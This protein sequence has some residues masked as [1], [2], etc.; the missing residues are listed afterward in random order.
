M[1]EHFTGYK[2]DHRSKKAMMSFIEHHR[3]HSDRIYDPVTIANCVKLSHLPIPHDLGDSAYAFLESGLFDFNLHMDVTDFEIENP[4][5]TVY[6]AGRTGGWLELHKKGYRSI[7]SVY[8]PMIDD[9]APIEDIRDLCDVIEAFD[10]WCDYVAA[11]FLQEVYDFKAEKEAEQI[12]VERESLALV[13]LP[14]PAMGV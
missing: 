2:I 10:R 14:F 7:F 5:Y 13:E 3:V 9:E 11:D 6:Q 1:I 8:D 12:E 4:G